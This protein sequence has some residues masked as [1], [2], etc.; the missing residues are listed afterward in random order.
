[1]L[2]EYLVWGFTF[3]SVDLCLCQGCSCFT[4]FGFLD[5][6]LWVIYYRLHFMLFWFCL[7]SFAWVLWLLYGGG[8]LCVCV[9]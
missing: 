8:F 2:S 7:S 1:M 9:V 4:S 6:R 5:L 3:V